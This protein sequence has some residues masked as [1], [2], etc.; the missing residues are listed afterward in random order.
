MLIV[1]FKHNFG[2]SYTIIVETGMFIVLFLFKCPLRSLIT[3]PHVYPCSS[4]TPCALSHLANTK[5]SLLS[6]QQC[7]LYFRF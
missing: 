2:W 6:L 3:R 7:L 5:Q 1:L 4:G